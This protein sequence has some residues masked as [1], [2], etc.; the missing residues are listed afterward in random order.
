MSW[1]NLFNRKKKRQPEKLS[2][3]IISGTI[4]A[5]VVSDL[6]NIRTNNEDVGMF[7][8]IADENISNEKGSMLIVAD[9]M[10]GH[11]AGEV[12]SRMA[13]QIITH[14][15]F[16]QNSSVERSLVK[17]FD[18][19]NKAIHDMAARSKAH[20]GMGTTCTAL[21]IFDKLIYY[22]HVGDSRAYIL[23]NDA[24]ERITEDH[25]HVQHLVKQGLLKPADAEKHP[26]RNILTNAMGTKPQVQVDAGKHQHSFEDSDRLLLCSDGLYD[27]IKDNELA[28]LLGSGSLQ[29][30]ANEMVAIQ[31]N[32]VVTIT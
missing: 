21:V 23:K 12:A 18:A 20:K 22:A 11:N 31:N 6:G 27:Y 32:V 10:G 5:V 4:K 16:K 29:D 7:F 19:A 17:A 3:E 30:A 2:H 26:D 15:Y 1:Y 8:R 28:E 24:I 13:T 14:E 9:G 25:T